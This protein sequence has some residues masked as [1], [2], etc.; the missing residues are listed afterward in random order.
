MKTDARRLERTYKE[1]EPGLWIRHP[2]NDRFSLS[3]IKRYKKYINV[4][5]KVVFDIG[6][7]FGGFARKAVEWGAEKVYTFE[8]LPENWE[9]VQRNIKRYKKIS[10]FNAA[11]VAHLNPTTSFYAPRG[12]SLGIGSR[13]PV[14]GREEI[15]VPALNFQSLLYMYKPEV[16]KMDIEGGEYDLLL[17]NPLPDFVKQIVMEIHYWSKP[18]FVN[19]KAP[20]LVAMFD[21]WE[22]V[23]KPNITWSN[24]CTIGAWKR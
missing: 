10:G 21:D 2:S 14:K 11:V 6:A 3:E 23:H 18:E 1:A 19:G 22:C 15:I 7:C 8:A 17:G 20:E 5:G 4:E 16:I 13:L 12:K 9:A 24:L